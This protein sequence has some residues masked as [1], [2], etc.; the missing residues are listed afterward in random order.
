MLDW[1]T[2][3]A[4]QLL[5]IG[6]VVAGWFFSKD[7]TSDDGCNA[8]A[9]GFRGPARVLAKPVR[10]LPIFPIRGGSPSGASGVALL[11]EWL[12]EC[13]KKPAIYLREI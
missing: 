6:G 2:W 1:L 9:G 12:Q 3:P 5:W 8:G 13:W 10:I 7:A 4:D 11:H